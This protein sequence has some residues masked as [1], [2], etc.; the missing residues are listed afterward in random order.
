MDA[1]RNAIA[2]GGDSDTMACIAGEISF[3]FYKYIPPRIVKK[4]KTY[5][6][7]EFLKEIDWFNKKFN[8]K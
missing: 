1:I 2:L 3:A 4:A 6:P 7:E 8:L 5:L